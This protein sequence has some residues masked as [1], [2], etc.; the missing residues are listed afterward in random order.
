MHI[1][2][3]DIIDGRAVP[4]LV[5]RENYTLTGTHRGTVHVET[6]EFILLGSLRGT[7]VVHSGSTVLIQGKQRGTVFIESGAIVKVSGEVNGTTSIEKNSTLIIEESGKLAGTSKID[8]S[9]IIRGIFGGATSGCGQ[10]I[11]EGNGIIK[12]PTIKNGVNYYEW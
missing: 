6:E 7:L 11:V 2:S 10:A 3:D 12:K 1:Y 8:G 4:P 9:L 5:I